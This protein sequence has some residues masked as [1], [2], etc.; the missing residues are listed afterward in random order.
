MNFRRGLIFLFFLYTAIYPRVLFCAE[1]TA[2]YWQTEKSQ[3]F[4]LYY[5]DA[6]EE[7]VSEIIN[8]AENYYNSIID[9]LGYRRFDFWNWDKRAKIFLY[10][11]SAA[12]LKE[13]NRSAWSGASVNVKERTIKTFNNQR[14]FFDSILPH[15]MTH[16][17]FHEFVG[18]KAKFPLW[19]DE[20]IAC[21]QEESSLKER[22][23]TTGNLVKQGIY[24]EF[25]NLSK[26]RDYSLIV[27]SVFYAQSA[28]IIVF[29]LNQYGKDKF[30]DFNRQ[31]RDGVQWQEALLK[32]YKFEDMNEFEAKLKE[33]FLK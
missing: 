28:S 15:E 31:L 32:S 4:I 17:I 3:H 7:Y 33:Y 13:T 21:S 24:L 26:I 11:N 22:L 6:S 18:D 23:R 19:L 16:I 12:Y 9:N 20:G 14:N 5:E 10:K 8:K 30:L 1:V 2:S 25:E 27:P 29:L